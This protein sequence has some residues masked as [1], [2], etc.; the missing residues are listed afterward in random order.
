MTDEYANLERQIVAKKNEWMQ[1]RA[2]EL[3]GQGSGEKARQLD[4]EVKV[5]EARKSQLEN[6]DRETEQEREPKQQENRMVR[7]MRMSRDR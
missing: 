1:A 5:L 6:K 4:A 3:Q 7:R 2:A